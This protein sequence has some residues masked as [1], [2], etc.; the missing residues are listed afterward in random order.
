M[1][2][3]YLKG[4]QDRGL[5]A[6]IVFDEVHVYLTQ[7]KFR[8]RI[9]NV[10]GLVTLQVPRLALSA[11]IPPALAPAIMKA[12]G[13]PESQGVIREPSVQPNVKYYFLSAR[14]T[15]EANEMAKRVYT[16][17]KAKYLEKDSRSQG[18][19]FFPK[20]DH[21]QAVATELGL[22]FHHSKLEDESGNPKQNKNKAL[23]DWTA[24]TTQ[25]IC[26]TSGLSTGID[27]PY[28]D[29]VIFAGHPWG[30]IDFYQAS[31]RCA[32]KGRLSTS[33]L[34]TVTNDHRPIMKGDV[35]MAGAMREFA[36]TQHACDREFLTHHLDGNGI[37]CKDL[38]D[39]KPCRM[40]GEDGTSVEI[41]WASRRGKIVTSK[42]AT[43]TVPVQQKSIP[44]IPLPIPTPTEP[45]PIP[46]RTGLKRKSVVSQD[47]SQ[48]SERP[49]KKANRGHNRMDSSASILSMS[50][51]SNSMIVSTSFLIQMQEREKLMKDV[52]NALE[53][54]SGK[55]LVCLLVDNKDGVPEYKYRSCFGC[56]N[57]MKQFEQKTG[58]M[59]SQWRKE[60][61]AY[62]AE[63][64]DKFKWCFACHIYQDQFQPPDHNFEKNGPDQPRHKYADIIPRV[65]FILK[66]SGRL[67]GG[68]S[69]DDFGRQLMD[70]TPRYNM[71]LDIFAGVFKDLN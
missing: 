42:S 51:S 4:L 15:D 20:I 18:I 17:A 11:T 50:S 14:T 39:T 16:W 71:M 9:K 67:M 56:L 62:S 64:T 54:F 28:V 60:H 43:T 35:Q 6:R 30:L 52:N 1:V 63:K 3:S 23:N 21:C 31:G 33:I 58:T 48:T 32:R 36:T 7:D 29:F 53:Y 68:E 8:Q 34:I 70:S 22:P 55:C 49:A 66:A 65:L 2:L 46:P 25:T 69:I 26:A 37:K 10:L 24:H 27:Q 38:P 12:V 5:L 44:A 47:I 41:L 59:Y 45:Q 19:I 57:R 40:C 13:L 61:V